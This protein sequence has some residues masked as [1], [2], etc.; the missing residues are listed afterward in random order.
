MT[1]SGSTCGLVYLGK[2]LLR[3]NNQIR[4]FSLRRVQMR[5]LGWNTDVCGLPRGRV[6]LLSWR[7]KFNKLNMDLNLLAEKVGPDENEDTL[8]YSA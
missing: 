7:A 6:S 3:H 2:P 1:F 5:S 4:H 8:S